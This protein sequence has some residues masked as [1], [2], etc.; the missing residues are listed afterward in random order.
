VVLLLAAHCMSA[1]QATQLFAAEQMGV[2]ALVQWA[3]VTQG[4]QAPVLVWQRGVAGFLA[5]H[6]M[7]LPQATQVLLAAQMG[8]FP[9]HCEW[10]VHWTQAPVAAQTGRP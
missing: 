10:L 3:L 8:V 1:V 2:V 9:E 7:S 6:S 4:T 5:A